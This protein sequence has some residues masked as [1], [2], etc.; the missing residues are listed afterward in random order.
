MTTY[1]QAGLTALT[2]AQF[3]GTQ[4]SIDAI[5]AICR[6][7]RVD[8][9]MERVIRIPATHGR[10]RLMYT[11]DWLNSPVAGSFTVY[12]NAEWTALFAASA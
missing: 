12:S 4:A 10:S 3:D 6:D 11:G 1:D 5:M 9:T 7:A 2:A 8:P